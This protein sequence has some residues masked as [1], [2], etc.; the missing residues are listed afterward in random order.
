MQQF[1]ALVIAVTLAIAP[2]SAWAWGDEGHKV[3]ALI[4]Q[5]YLRE[6]DPVTLARVDA[7]LLS[8]GDTLTPPDIASRAT[9]ADRYRDSD[10]NTTKIRY[11][12]TRAWH[13]I[14]I[15]TA[16]AADR[17]NLDAPCHDHPG[18]IGGAAS[19]SPDNCIVD[20][21]NQF[22]VELQNLSTAPEERLTALR[23]LLHF[24]GDIHQPLHAAER[25]GDQGGN[26]VSVMWTGHTS[27]LPL[28]RYWDDNA[29]AAWGSDPQTVADRL[30]ALITPRELD[31]AR[32]EIDPARWAIESWRVARR[33]VYDLPTHPA[34]QDDGKPYYRLSDNY[35]THAKQVAGERL[36]FAGL[37]LALVLQQHLRR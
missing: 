33:D 11:M 14:D 29:V 2:G 24:V 18:V 3:V 22:E 37:R 10:R 32:S 26:L 30:Y 17:P 36:R 7:L 27:R 16:D 19:G 13:Y 9:W 1:V 23:F 34:G 31:Q 21:I 15:D 35:R 8:D 25:N 20:K 6:S 4:A 12:L 5:R 28:H